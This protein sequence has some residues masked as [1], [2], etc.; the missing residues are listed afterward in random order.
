MITDYLLLQKKNSTESVVKESKG[1]GKKAR[2]HEL[3]L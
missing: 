1:V 2:F 3:L